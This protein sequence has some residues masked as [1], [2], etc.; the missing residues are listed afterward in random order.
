MALG[1]QLGW[2]EA[3]SKIEANSKELIVLEKIRLAL[4]IAW[5]RRKLE[6]VDNYILR[7]YTRE[8][9]LAII[10]EPWLHWTSNS[11][12]PA[13]AELHTMSFRFNVQFKD[14]LAS[15]WQQSSKFEVRSSTRKVQSSKFTALNF[16][17]LHN[18]TQMCLYFDLWNYEIHNSLVW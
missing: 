17:L 11:I 16:N 6:P 5:N 13:M 18:L 8:K 3:Q 12:I 1:R 9:R 2:L 4:W 15:C 7:L 10:H 14:I